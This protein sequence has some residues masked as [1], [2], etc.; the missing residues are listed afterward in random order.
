MTCPRCGS[1]KFIPGGICPACNFKDE[2]RRLLDNQAANEATSSESVA[3]VKSRIESQTANTGEE[4]P[5]WRL[6]LWKRLESLKMEQKTEESGKQI[7]KKQTPPVPKI[8]QIDQSV[9]ES[10]PPPVAGNEGTAMQPPRPEPLTRNFQDPSPR[11]KTIASLGEK[12]FQTPEPDHSDNIRDL[13]DITVSRQ[14]TKS[15]PETSIF[16]RRTAVDPE[17]KYIL[18]SRTLGGLIDLIIVLLCT[19]AFVIAADSFSGI[20]VLDHISIIEYAALFLMIFLFYSIFFLAASGQTIGMMITDLRVIGIAN[21]RPSIS[22]LFAR[23]FGYLLSVIVLGVGLFWSFFDR[24]NRCLH[25][26]LSDTSVIR[27]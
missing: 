26:R 12:V 23:C 20:V 3:G 1:E 10:A 7:P 16:T 6:E 14:S 2:P 13:I 24:K 17:N 25:D 5:E 9:P 4:I 18:L 21:S 15:I 11:Q 8:I 22:Q 19:A 27:I